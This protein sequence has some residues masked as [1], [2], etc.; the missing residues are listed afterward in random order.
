VKGVSTAFWAVVLL[1]STFSIAAGF[2]GGRT[3]VAAG[4]LPSS[5]AA[6][7]L[8]PPTPIVLGAPHR[9]L[10]GAHSLEAA[11]APD[12]YAD[13]S[14]GVAVHAWPAG[15]FDGMR[16]RAKIAILIADASRAGTE[17]APFVA[18][19]LPFGFVVAPEDGQAAQVRDA[20]LGAGKVVLVDG[21][22]AKPSEV[23]ALGGGTAG[24]WGSCDVRRARA[25]MRVLPPDALVVDAAMSE[26]D[27]LARIA[28]G[29]A[30]R[31]LVR[32]VL[33]DARSNRRY[34]DYML[35]D[36]LAIAQRHGRAILVVHGRSETFEAVGRFSERAR[37]AGADIV[38]ITSIES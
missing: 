8:P 14:L 21:T 4:A 11:D 28:G 32:D 31:V 25:L 16:E 33:A 15:R 37:R 34:V 38:P 36:A 7:A 19:A 20:A 30:R 24:I 3:V 27:A 26:D 18:S 17:L 10:Q 5:R 29:G 35:A 22:A 9:Q 1:G 13:A 12:P 6:E 2:V 23:A